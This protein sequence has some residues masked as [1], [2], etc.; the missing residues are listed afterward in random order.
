MPSTASYALR[1][2][3]RKSSK[4]DGSAS[5]AARSVSFPLPPIGCLRG[6]VSMGQF[7]HVINAQEKSFD[8][9]G[10]SF[11]YQF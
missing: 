7:M 10:L 3:A 5:H 6:M 1:P 4:T 11:E 9:S 2:S 8:F